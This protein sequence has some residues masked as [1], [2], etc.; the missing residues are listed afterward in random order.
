MNVV[1]TTSLSVVYRLKPLSGKFA[2]ESTIVRMTTASDSRSR[3]FR[4]LP[5]NQDRSRDQ[6]T[7][8]LDFAPSSPPAERKHSSSKDSPY[9]KTENNKLSSHRQSPY[10][11]S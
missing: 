11:K 5:S 2:R 1:T 4:T 3:P 10:A 6:P 8:K 9:S 7:P